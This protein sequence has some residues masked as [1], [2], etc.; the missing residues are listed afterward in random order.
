M[1]AADG[2]SLTGFFS[3]CLGAGFFAFLLVVSPVF[4]ALTG[5]TVAAFMMMPASGKRQ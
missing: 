4:A 3:I 2:S 1:K 5:F